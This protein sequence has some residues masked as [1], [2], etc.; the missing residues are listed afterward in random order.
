MPIF[1]GTY[2]EKFIRFTNRSDGLPIGD[3]SS[4]EFSG[5]LEDASGTVVLAM[6]TS[7]GQIT[8]NDGPN[9]EIKIAFTSDETEAMS[10]GVVSAAVLR[11]DADPGP[12]R[13]FRIETQVMEVN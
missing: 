4:W 3:I 6:S 2:F 9:A 7:G 8:V 11:T 1:K 5:D 13:M 12:I 10:V